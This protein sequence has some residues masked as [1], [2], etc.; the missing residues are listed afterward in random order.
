MEELTLEKF[1]EAS[2][3]VREVTTETKL[4]LIHIF[5]S[6]AVIR[7]SCSYW[8]TVLGWIPMIPAISDVE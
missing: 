1:E 3:L 8:R 2:D 6:G 7:Q 5:L 4:S